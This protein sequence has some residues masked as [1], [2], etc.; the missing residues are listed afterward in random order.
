MAIALALGSLVSCHNDKIEV[1]KIPKENINVAMQS[2]LANSAPPGN[3]AQWN[4]P[5]GWVEQPLS[6]MR[7]GS[8]KVEGANNASADVSVIA[9]AGEAGGLISNINRWR[10]QLQ[11]APLDEDQLSQAIQHTEVD[12][13]PTALVDFRTAENS[14]KPSRILGAVLQAADRTWFV[15]MTG[16]PE[17]LET[18]RQK[19][20]EFV[21]SFRFTSRT[22]TE[23][24]A[25][26]V[27]TAPKS[28]NDK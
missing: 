23:P 5:D 16:P 18:Q 27:P 7:L 25:P 28:T 8:F 3:P 26:G 9:F 15:K 22:Q 6:E 2:G 14:P 11:L 12:N 19:F 21:Q 20:S 1:Y 24:P 17:L 13:V 10:G 4:K